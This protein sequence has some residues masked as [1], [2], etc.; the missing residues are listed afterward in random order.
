[1]HWQLLTVVLVVAAPAPPEKDKK[2]EEKIQGTWTIVSAQSGG[3]NKPADETKAI[4]F[5]IK[6]D[7]ITIQDPKREEKATFKLDSTK[8]PKTIDLIPSEKEGKGEPVLGIYEL[9]DDDLKICF[10]H[11]GKGGR[12]TEFASKADTNL[13]LIVLKRAKKDK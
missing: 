5:I 13:S 8:K 2:D 6:G 12:P 7:L 3:E 11:G 4:K 10:V 1:M 9:K